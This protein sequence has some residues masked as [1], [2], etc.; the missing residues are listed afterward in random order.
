MH[1]PY[2]VPFEY[3]HSDLFYLTCYLKFIVDVS[4]VQLFVENQEHLI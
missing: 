4:V 2:T 3:N 1:N